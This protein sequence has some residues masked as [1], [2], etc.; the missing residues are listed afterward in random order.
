MSVPSN[1]RPLSSSS[2]ST[3]APLDLFT[4]LHSRI[5]NLEEKIAGQ[6]AVIESMD[7]RLKSLEGMPV[8]FSFLCSQPFTFHLLNVSYFSVRPALAR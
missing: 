3:V 5:V 2:S 6:Q 8:T 4:Q 7:G 1:P